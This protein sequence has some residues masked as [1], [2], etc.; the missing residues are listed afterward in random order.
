MM[1]MYKILFYNYKI[2][3]LFLEFNFYNLFKTFILKQLKSVDFVLKKR[4]LRLTAYKKH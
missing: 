3:L 4:E 2:I 1:Q